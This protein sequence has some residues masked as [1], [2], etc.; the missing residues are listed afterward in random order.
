M[1]NIFFGKLLNLGNETR[2]L[3]A[4]DWDEEKAETI[5]EAFSKSIQTV[6]NEK[7]KDKSDAINK[8]KLE[9]SAYASS[10]QIDILIEILEESI[11]NSSC[12]NIE[13]EYEN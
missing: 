3:E 1:F 2:L 5:K 7:C 4:C 10:S 12:V 8:I 11:E 9:M 6:F 13:D